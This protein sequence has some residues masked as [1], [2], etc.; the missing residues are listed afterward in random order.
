MP[1]SWI[2]HAYMQPSHSLSTGRGGRHV[3]KLGLG[4]GWPKLGSKNLTHDEADLGLPSLFSLTRLPRT[5]F[6][7][8]ALSPEGSGLVQL[9]FQLRLCSFWL[10][11]VAG[12]LGLS[13]STPQCVSAKCLC[14]CSLTQTF[15]N[16]LP[17]TKHLWYS[18]P[19]V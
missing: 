13:E 16:T 12:A 11:S 7:G 19:S 15:V 3:V 2:S 18:F 9:I 10:L 6:S 4:E 5:K 8:P 17:H 1:L 14:Q